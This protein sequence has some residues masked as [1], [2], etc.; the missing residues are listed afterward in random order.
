MLQAQHRRRDIVL[1]Q[2]HIVSPAHRARAHG[3]AHS[4]L[5]ARQWPLAC[6][7]LTCAQRPSLR[8]L[9]GSSRPKEPLPFSLDRRRPLLQPLSAEKVPIPLLVATQQKGKGT[10]FRDKGKGKGKGFSKGGWW[11]W[12][13]I[14]HEPW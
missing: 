8:H 7:C 5:Q 1:P 4:L 10:P 2:C 14:W 12:Y 6:G 11:D 9:E 3:R 13:G